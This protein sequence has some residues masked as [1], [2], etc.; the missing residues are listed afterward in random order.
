MKIHMKTLNEYINEKLVISK[1]SKIFVPHSKKELI[2]TLNNLIESKNYNFNKIDVSG[3]TDLSN[4]FISVKLNEDIDVS[5]WDVSHVTNMEG[6]F[7]GFKGINII[8]IENWDVSN[9]E[10]MENMFADC[11]LINCDLS[12]WDVSKVTNF[13]GMF[14]ECKKFDGKGLEKWDVSNG[15]HFFGMFHDCNNLDC[16]L[17]NWNIKE[18]A[19]T[20]TMFKG[21]GLSDDKK[22]KN[23]K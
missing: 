5:N 11:E 16:D 10:N 21:C 2:N 9:V 22:P 14:S 7:Y 1:N 13:G 19:I 4:I 3:I 8:G 15:D 6:L 23:I 20:K 12:K 17:S 18:D